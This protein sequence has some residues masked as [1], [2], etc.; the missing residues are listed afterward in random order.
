M[1]LRAAP[2]EAVARLAP[3]AS[4]VV[5]DRGYARICRQWRR[6]LAAELAP[7]LRLVQVEA[8]AVRRTTMA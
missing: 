2:P 7:D 5:V 3:A 6:R 1:C 4:S 8:A